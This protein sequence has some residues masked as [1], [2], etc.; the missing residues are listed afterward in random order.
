MEEHVIVAV[1]RD[2]LGNIIKIRLDDGQEWGIKEAIILGEGGYLKGCMVQSNLG[3]K[4]I[5][6][7]NDGDPSNNLDNLPSF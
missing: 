1:R 2:E 4:Y 7:V 3:G 5:K 6:S